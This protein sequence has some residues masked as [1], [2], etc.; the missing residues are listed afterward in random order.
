MQGFLYTVTNN[1]GVAVTAAN[2]LLEATVAAD[3]PVYLHLLEVLQTTDLGDA[4]EEVLKIGI[5]RGVTAGSG[6]TAATENGLSADNPA[7]ATAVTTD[8]TTASTGGTLIR[9]IGWNI[10]IPTVW[11]PVPEWRPKVGADEDP[12]SFRL[13]AA[14]TDSVTI[15]HTHGWEEV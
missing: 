9:H 12:Y 10:R 13:I 14:P 3:R 2:D 4:A 5:Y 15:S 7:A 6:G 1:G 11:E 8:R